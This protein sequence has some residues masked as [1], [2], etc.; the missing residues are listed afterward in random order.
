MAY[1]VFKTATIKGEKGTDWLIHI[2]KKNY[3][4]SSSELNLFGE[5]FEIKWSGEGGT[6]NRQYL[7]SE[8]VLKTFIESDPD[9]SFLHDIF[10]KGD[11]E[12]FIRIYKG[13][14]SADSDYILINFL[15]NL[16][17]ILQTL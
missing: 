15:T 14:T 12:Y 11:K 5:G 7:T 10:T 16:I 1:G 8:C 2:H 13:V 6:R 9:E 17:H 4:G 3:S